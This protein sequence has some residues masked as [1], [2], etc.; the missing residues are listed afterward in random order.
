MMTRQTFTPLWSHIREI[1]GIAMRLVDGLPADRLDETPIPNM[2][3]VKQLLVHMYGS[4]AKAVTLGIITGEIIQPVEGTVI[5]QLKTKD[6]VVRYCKECWSAADQAAAKVTDAQLAATVKTPW[7][8]NMPGWMCGSVVQDELL[9]HRGQLYCFARAL[10]A[11]EV[12][13]M[14][15]FANNAPEYQAKAGASA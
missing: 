10:G 9:H 8:M 7:G 6:D 15:D 11:K 14:W 5:A 13:M 12:P 4:M 3:S 1:N 2:R